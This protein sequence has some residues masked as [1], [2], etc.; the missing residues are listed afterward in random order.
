MALM[1]AWMQGESERY[2]SQMGIRVRDEEA[3]QKDEEQEYADVSHQ[4]TYYD[5]STLHPGH[6]DH[7]VKRGG[8]RRGRGNETAV[9]HEEHSTEEVVC[10]THTHTN[11]RVIASVQVPDAV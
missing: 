7:R 8:R 6:W 10:K 9:E 11:V 2:P 4:R 1:C 5:M 3:P